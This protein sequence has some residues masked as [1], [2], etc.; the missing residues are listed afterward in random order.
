MPEAM[1]LDNL[2]KARRS[3]EM[4]QELEFIQKVE[5]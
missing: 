1:S 5:K 3:L 4:T 2:D